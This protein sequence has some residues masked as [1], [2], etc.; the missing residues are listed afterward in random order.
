MPD[1][2]G[3]HLWITAAVIWD[4][5]KAA[6]KGLTSPIEVCSCDLHVLDSV[7]DS[8]QVTWMTMEHWH[9]AQ[10]MDPTLGL[11]ITDCG[12]KCWGNDS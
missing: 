3:T 4:M 2:S 9:Q 5:Q 8:Q 7:W 12:M 11:G 10:Q 1:N 6:L